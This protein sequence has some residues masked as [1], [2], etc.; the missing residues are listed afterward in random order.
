MSVEVGT[1]IAAPGGT[2]FPLTRKR[3]GSPV[4]SFDRHGHV[5]VGRMMPFYTLAKAAEE[6]YAG[7]TYL[8]E[9]GP[10]SVRASS[11]QKW[12]AKFSSRDSN[13]WVVYLMQRGSDFRVGWCQFFDGNGTNH[14]T[15]RTRIERADCMWVLS[16][17]R[18]KADASLEESLVASRFGLP[19]V[20][21][22]ESH[23]TA[24]KVPAVYSQRRLDNFF[25]E[26]RKV[27]GDEVDTRVARCL[28]HH[29]RDLRYPFARVG[30]WSYRRG[31][32]TNFCTESCNL[33]TGVMS[34]AIRTDDRREVG[35]AEVS[36]A[37]E[38][39]KKG[40]RMCSAVSS[41]HGYV[42]ANG[43]LA[44]PLEGR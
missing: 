31:R 37:Q 41:K 22:H 4:V 3:Q 24:S 23:P 11:E 43:I 16:V 2:Y 18:T 8:V 27:L 36:V 39:N 44:A 17:H 10:Y 19:L 33:L 42:V 1:Q 34:L 6:D 25:R 7:P 29:Q 5:F 30:A 32:T 40:R 26:Y 15:L 14:L 35:W 20:Q 21:F 9:A 28:A 13:L 12:L 38:H